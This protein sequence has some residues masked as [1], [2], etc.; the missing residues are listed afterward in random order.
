MRE[1][2]AR[3]HSSYPGSV[4][5]GLNSKENYDFDLFELSCSCQLGDQKVRSVGVFFK[6]AVQKS[7]PQNIYSSVLAQIVS[8][9]RMKIK[10]PEHFLR[11]TS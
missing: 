4:C 3:S 10:L 1:S 2:A 5:S 11:G 9:E 7:F 6:N 8:N